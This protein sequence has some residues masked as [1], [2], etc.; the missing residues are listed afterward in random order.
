MWLLVFN[1]LP[2]KYIH[3]YGEKPYVCSYYV[4]TAPVLVCPCRFLPGFASN[5]R[6]SFSYFIALLTSAP[7]RSSAPAAS[8]VQS[9]CNQLIPSVTGCSVCYCRGLVCHSWRNK[10]SKRS[11]N[12][13][14]Y[15]YIFIH[16]CIFLAENPFMF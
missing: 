13:P 12:I 6:P 3:R 15:S 7:S 16:F 4:S 1:I 14:I 2:W 10:S 5:S 8:N 9:V 11:T